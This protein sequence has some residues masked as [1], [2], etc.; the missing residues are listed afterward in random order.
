V[1]P[2]PSFDVGFGFKLV[3]EG[4]IKHYLEGVAPDGPAYAAGIRQGDAIIAVND[5]DVSDWT[6]DAL[7]ATLA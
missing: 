7:V 3:E 5:Q 1:R 6:H 4:S 2:R